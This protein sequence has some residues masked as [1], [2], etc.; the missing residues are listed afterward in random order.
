MMAVVDPMSF[1]EFQSLARLYVVG[2]LDEEELADFALAR[3]DFGGRA[4]SYLAECER[5]ASAFALSLEPQP[6]A[7]DAREDLLARIRATAP[8]QPKRRWFH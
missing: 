3:E 4:D 8:N 7:P 1:E 6:P 2:G 5:L